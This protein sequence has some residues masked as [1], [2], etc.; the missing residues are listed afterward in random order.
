[1]NAFVLNK[2]LP[3][4]YFPSEHRI[5]EEKKELLYDL[6]A[7]SNHFGSTGGGHYT[8]FCK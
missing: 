2:D 8:A 5:Q 6:V 3:E 1:M 7:I 4:E